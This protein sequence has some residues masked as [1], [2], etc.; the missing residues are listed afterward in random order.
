MTPAQDHNHTAGV[1]RCREEE[2]DDT[3][4]GRV[5]KWL[6]SAPFD[7]ENTQSYSTDDAEESSELPDESRSCSSYQSLSSLGGRPVDSDGDYRDDN[8]WY[9]GIEFHPEKDLPADIQGLA[10]K[11]MTESEPPDSLDTERALYEKVLQLNTAGN[12]RDKK[13]VFE[14]LDGLAFEHPGEL[15]KMERSHS[16]RMSRFVVG[17]RWKTQQLGYMTYADRKQ[18]QINT[19]APDILYGYMPLLFS[20]KH[21]GQ[22]ITTL[23]DMDNA[24]ET[25][26]LTLPFLVV[27]IA[28]DG[29]NL[30][31]AHNQCA[32]GMASCVKMGERLA[33]ALPSRDPAPF[34]S[35]VFGIVTDGKT[36]E[37]SV[38]WRHAPPGGAERPSRAVFNIR[39]VRS[40]SLNEEAQCRDFMRSVHKIIKW[41]KVDRLGQIEKVLDELAREDEQGRDE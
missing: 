7:P 37:L 31:T 21:R 28:L 32:T 14:A 35:A 34:C 9:N 6:E 12:I 27:D 16:E 24:N 41:G 3:P 2:D 11:M 13:K 19:P 15:D 29:D 23:D 1:Q 40:F 30:L 33:S 18:R 38:C 26:S 36:A 25:T 22:M 20:S 8:L 4:N 17:R 39:P 5:L 10:E